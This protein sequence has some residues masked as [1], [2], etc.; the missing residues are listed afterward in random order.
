MNKNKLTALCLAALLCCSIFAG[1]KDKAPEQQNTPDLPEGA[2]TAPVSP[3]EMQ[4]LIDQGIIEDPNAPKQDIEPAPYSKGVIENNVY[5]NEACNLTL[6]IPAGWIAQDDYNLCTLMG[7][8]Y[9]F[10]NDDANLKAISKLADIYDMMASDSTQDQNIMVLMQ[11]LNQHGLGDKSAAEYLDVMKEQ[12]TSENTTSI[13]ADFEVEE[14]TE[15]SYSGNTYSMMKVVATPEEGTEVTQYF[16][17][18]EAN[19]RMLTVMMTFPSA[20]PINPDTI[21]A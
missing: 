15:V 20:D 17:L 2:V 14:I 11:D 7:V 1:C 5:R 3:E 10:E 9:D 16:F 18:R 4:D 21:F 19:E 8:T 13:N 6:R 12:L